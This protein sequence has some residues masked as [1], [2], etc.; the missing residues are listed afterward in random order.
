LGGVRA[1]TL[2]DGI[3]SAVE[4]AHNRGVW[5]RD[6]NRIDCFS[7]I[8]ELLSLVNVMA[9]TK[10]RVSHAKKQSVRTI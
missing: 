4:F 10:G 1:L 6:I 7:Q 5:Q 2:L 8:S 9:L 3:L